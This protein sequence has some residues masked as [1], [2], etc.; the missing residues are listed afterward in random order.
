MAKY[1]VITGI[2]KGLKFNG[3]PIVINGESRI[4]NDDST[5]QSFPAENC[6][7]VSDKWTKITWSPFATNILDANKYDLT[8]PNGDS[9]YFYQSMRGFELVIGDKKYYS[10]NNIEMS[11]IFNYHEIGGILRNQFKKS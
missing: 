5:G 4:W 1:E 3:F 9:V 7:L 10:D 8:T 11:Y 6:K 2:F